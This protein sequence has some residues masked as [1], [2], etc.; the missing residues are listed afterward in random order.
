MGSKRNNRINS[1][2]NC[3]NLCQ[4][5][6]KS[7]IGLLLGL[8]ILLHP[9]RARA[10]SAPCAI[11]NIVEVFAG[12]ASCPL[13]HYVVIELVASGPGAVSSLDHC[14]R[15]LGDIDVSWAG[16]GPVGRKYLVARP[17]AAALFGIDVDQSMRE[18]ELVP[19]PDGHLRSWCNWNS[20]LIY[21]SYPNA[22]A[23]ALVPGKA[24]RWNG[25]SWQLVDPTPTNAAGDVGILGSCPSEAGVS[26]DAG[27]SGVGP[28]D[29]GYPACPSE[30]G[31][32][33][34]AGGTAGSG[35]SGAGGTAGSGGSAQK[36]A[37]TAGAGGTGI[38]DAGPRATDPGTSDAGCTCHTPGT[39]K[40]SGYGGLALAGVLCALARRRRW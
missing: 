24:L 5:L 22:T 39:G 4:A 17:E 31:G 16:H 33:S 26:N 15:R 35:G 19:A 14:G 23:P 36:E 40:A 8:G 11:F 30:E 7:C 2:S 38:T 9:A 29:G 25:S 13:A 10:E 28:R 18:Q 20:A 3:A 37:G 27:D 1:T 34:G 6:A 12:T 21:G 32:S